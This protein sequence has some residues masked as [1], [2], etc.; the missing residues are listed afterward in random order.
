[1]VVI[2]RVPTALTGVTHER[3]AVPSTRTV[4][5]PQTPRPQPNLVPRSSSVSRNTQSSGISAEAAIE[6]G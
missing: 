5:A 4:Q 1:M 3:V 2:R 6:R